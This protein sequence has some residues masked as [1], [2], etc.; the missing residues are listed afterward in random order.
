MD[1]L[2]IGTNSSHT[3]SKSVAANARAG[4]RVKSGQ[5]VP[6]TACEKVRRYLPARRSTTECGK[7]GGW[8]G[9]KTKPHISVCGVLYG[10]AL[11]ANLNHSQK[12]ISANKYGQLTRLGQMAV[13]MRVTLAQVG[14]EQLFPSGYTKPPFNAATEGL[15]C[16]AAGRL[17]D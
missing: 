5:R 11:G 2:P 12:V 16:S 17:V 8:G 7:D 13:P 10:S 14:M 6:S 3:T 4:I 9:L 15:R 1:E